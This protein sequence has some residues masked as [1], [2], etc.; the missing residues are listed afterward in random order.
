MNLAGDYDLQVDE[1]IPELKKLPKGGKR[2]RPPQRVCALQPRPKSVCDRRLI[3]KNR[4]RHELS[5]AH[6]G[7][8]VGSGRGGP[9]SSVIVGAHAPFRPDFVRACAVRGVGESRE[10]LSAFHQEVSRLDAALH[11][12]GLNG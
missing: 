8:I 10:R 1:C 12:I 6:S 2:E 7:W 11:R 5:R 3:W 9:V 4:R